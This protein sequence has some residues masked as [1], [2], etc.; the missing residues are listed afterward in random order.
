MKYLMILT[1]LQKFSNIKT[2]L[3]LGSLNAAKD[4]ILM[5]EVDEV[6]TQERKDKY[7]SMI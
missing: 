4:L 1:Q 3:E 6:F 2:L 7:L 5:S